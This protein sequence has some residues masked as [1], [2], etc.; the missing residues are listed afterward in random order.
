MSSLAAAQKPLEG[1][2][3]L[4]F[5]GFPLHPPRRSGTERAEHLMQVTVPMLFLQGTR[6]SF[7]DL[8][9]LRPICEKLAGR[10]KLHIVETADH[11]FR[12]LKRSGRTDQDVLCELARTA[13]EWA[14][15]I[16]LSSP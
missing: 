10:A 8:G 13:A 16:D 15:G 2:R 12:V 11:S 6:D 4:V 14:D 5:F 1:V 9:L 3:G 7:A